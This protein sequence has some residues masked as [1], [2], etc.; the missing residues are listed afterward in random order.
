MQLKALVPVL[1][2]ASGLIG[3]EELSDISSEFESGTNAGTNDTNDTHNENACETCRSE[4]TV[5]LRWLPENTD[6]VGYK[7]YYSSDPYVSERELSVLD[8]SSEDF[9]L[10]AP[11]VVYHAWDD[12]S[13]YKG[14]NVCFRIL[15]VELSGDETLSQEACGIL[16]DDTQTAANNEPEDEA[17]S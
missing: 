5:E 9:D 4:E 7:I 8:S 12:L 14:D 13:L 10:Q 1:I 17:V 2:L 3:C 11:A 15:A 16:P 6:I